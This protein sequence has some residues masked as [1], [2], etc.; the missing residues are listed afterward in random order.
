MYFESEYFICL[1]IQGG[2]IAIHFIHPYHLIQAWLYSVTQSLK[3]VERIIFKTGTTVIANN[4]KPV[5]RF[6]S[7]LLKKYIKSGDNIWQWPI[8]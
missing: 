5:E 6:C 1:G 4:I 7:P 3:S 8:I 2:N